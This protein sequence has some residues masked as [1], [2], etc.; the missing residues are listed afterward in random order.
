MTKQPIGIVLK[1]GKIGC[2][3][4]SVRNYHYLLCND[5]EEQTS[6]PL[7]GGSL[8]SHFILTCKCV[9]HLCWKFERTNSFL[10]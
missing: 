1:M 4:N 6:Y 2:S 7:N 3:E 5:A 9:V 8:K 10:W